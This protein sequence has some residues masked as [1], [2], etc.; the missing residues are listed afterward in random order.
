M[1]TFEKKPYIKERKTFSD[2]E[3]GNFFVWADQSDT[4][5]LKISA[6]CYFKVG[7]NY[8]YTVCDFVDDIARH[9]LDIENST[10]TYNSPVY[11]IEFEEC[12]VNWKVKL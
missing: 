7:N 3:T 2:L 11:E 6:A 10:Y 12:T 5:L 1:L 9:D 4:L 8:T